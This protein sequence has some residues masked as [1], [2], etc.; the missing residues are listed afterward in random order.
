MPTRTALFVLMWLGLTAAGC[1]SIPYYASVRGPVRTIRI[2]DADTGQDVPEATVSLT[3]QTSERFLG[4]PPS[5]LTCPSLFEIKAAA[6]GNLKRSEDLSF[7]APV[8]LAEGSRG[9]CVT[10]SGDA[11][12]YPRGII[13][14]DARGY[15]SAKLRYTVGQI[16]PGWSCSETCEDSEAA[17]PGS[18]H[19]ELSGRS[20]TARCEFGNDGVL[21]FYLPPIKSASTS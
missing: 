4:P 16:Q 7:P 12:Q 17:P 14:V 15:R 2:L 11:N 21:R 9:I 18:A 10:T 6:A 19:E 3:S 8:G 20:N 5:F 13:T 1:I